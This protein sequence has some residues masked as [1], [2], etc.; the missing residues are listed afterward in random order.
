MILARRPAATLSPTDHGID[1]S[2]NGRY[3]REA[4]GWS[5]RYVAGE[6]KAA[7][8]AHRIHVV[9][10]GAP[11][12][13]GFEPKSMM[14]RVSPELLFSWFVGIGVDAAARNHSVISK[15]ANARRRARSRRIW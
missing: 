12:R 1:P 7:G 3:L 11:E 5:R 9:A 2:A 10:L 14:E 15:N 8:L 4:D 6:G 13:L